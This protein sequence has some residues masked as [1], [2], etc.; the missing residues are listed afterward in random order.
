MRR[1]GRGSRA[2]RP[3]ARA[4]SGG[5]ADP[6]RL[7]IHRHRVGPDQDGAPPQRRTAAS[8]ERN[9][10]PPVRKST[11]EP[12]ASARQG[13][14]ADLPRP[15]RSTTRAGPMNAS[16]DR[17]PIGSPSGSTWEGVHVR[18]HVR[19]HR[20]AGGFEQR[21]LDEARRRA[22]AERNVARPDGGLLVDPPRDVQDLQRM[23]RTVFFAAYRSATCGS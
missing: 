22:P 7:G 15:G 17:R 18:S 3:R 8:G 11:R 21:A 1:R 9:A 2:P 14:R 5:P 4:A 19:A 23:R 12:E 16:R 10:L 20:E 6:R 13:V